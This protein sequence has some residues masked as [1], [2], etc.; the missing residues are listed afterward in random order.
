M[1]WVTGPVTKGNENCN[2]FLVIMNRFSNI[3]RYLPCHKEDTAMDTAFSFWNNIIANCRVPRI[4]ISYRDPKFKSEVWTNLYD[5]LGTKIS[6]STAYHPQT[7][8]LSVRMIQ[9]MQDII[10]RICAYGMEYKCH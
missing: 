9:T 5:M 2:F 6:F 1:D 3:V 10:S 8:V 4:I 7:N